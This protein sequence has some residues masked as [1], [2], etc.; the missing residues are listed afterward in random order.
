[1]AAGSG[2]RFKDRP[3]AVAAHATFKEKNLRK[4]TK[5]LNMR[6]RACN[7]VT[8]A[9]TCDVDV[10]GGGDATTAQ[11][12]AT[13]TSCTKPV[14]QTNSTELVAKPADSAKSSHL[15]TDSTSTSQVKLTSTTS[16]DV[17]PYFVNVSGED[18]NEGDDVTRQQVAYDDM[19]MFNDSSAATTSSSTTNAKRRKAKRKPKKM[20]ADL[21]PHMRKYW[22][23]RYR[24]FSRFDE[25]IKMD[26][27]EC[28]HGV[29]LV[30]S[31]TGRP[32]RL[33]WSPREHM[34]SGGTS[35][36]NRVTSRVEML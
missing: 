29:F 30:T 20:P 24:L 22:M 32:V 23:Q 25:G 31:A 35:E 17:T 9:A 19:D 26:A 6:K 4:W 27:G 16:D 21:A 34:S 12:Q 18:E 1:M 15:K 33:S 7:V 3:A 13:F 8:S 10:G 14:L 28:C 5:T 36:S 11:D 2:N